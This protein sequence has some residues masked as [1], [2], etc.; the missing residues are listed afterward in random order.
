MKH[1]RLSV[2][3][4]IKRYI[5]GQ[6]IPIVMMI[7]ISL[8][9]L[10]ITLISPVFF[11]ILIDDVFVAR[12][13][14]AFP[15]V[16]VGLLSIYLV[17]FILDGG[18]LYFGNRLLNHF[19]DSLRNDI[20]KKYCNA[21]YEYMEKMDAGDMKLRAMDDI[22]AL[23]NFL[24]EQVVDYLSA[25]VLLALSL[26]L[27]FLL[28]PWLTLL[29]VTILPPLFLFNH[30]IGRGSGKV[31]EEIRQV[32]EEYSSSTHS[33]LQAWREIK[34]QNAQPLFVER[35]AQYRRQFAKLGLKA[36]RYWAYTEVLNDFKSNYLSKAWVYIVGAVFVMKNQLSIGELVLFSEYFSFL[37][38][39]LDT[40]NARN[41]ALK[42]SLPYYQRVF[43]TLNMP[44]VN[45]TSKIPLKKLE[46]ISVCGLSFEYTPAAAVLKGIDLEVNRGDYI[47]IVGK[48]GCGKTTLAKLL[49]GLYEPWQGKILYN[50][51]SIS[52][53]DR[54]ALYRQLGV[55]M[56]DGYL[57][58]MSI[59]DN[60]L[61][62]QCA[63][64]D[65]ELWE[66]CRKANILDFIQSLPK[67]LDTVVGERGVK[68]S[69]GQKQRLCIAQAMLKQPS[70]FLFDEATS[71]LDGES[72]RMVHHS[73]DRIAQDAAVIVIS[74][75]PSCVLRAN[76]IVVMKDGTIQDVG[77]H[78]ELLS[79]N[80]YYQQIMKEA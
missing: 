8:A 40:I 4:K 76:K 43:E 62:C 7:L 33:A 2:L 26:I 21:P 22:D 64:T 17:R 73:I 24:R 35:F 77:S 52:Q 15:T 67:G 69:G 3:K 78:H 32:Q 63:A 68:L 60:L 61:L 6:K 72:E 50:G 71:S 56:Q 41:V 80:Q 48:T 23:G 53:L 13:W 59:R 28:H 38:Q 18:A 44:A 19:T 47:A 25:C 58:N 9:A 39:A 34:A 42:I 5:H 1:S 49:L 14:A 36:I 54:T 10:P 30:W 74:H 79:R 66:A 29:C 51:V 46:Q 31:N 55:V 75:K 11:Q 27:C 70:V 57:F 12:E 37:F 16:A 65:Q 20:L 45:T